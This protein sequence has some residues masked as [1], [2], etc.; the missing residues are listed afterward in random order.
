MLEI[1]VQKLLFAFTN[2]H[3]HMLDYE[4]I[5]LITAVRAPI[6]FHFN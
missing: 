5:H 1:F 3:V 4:D 6:V 2:V